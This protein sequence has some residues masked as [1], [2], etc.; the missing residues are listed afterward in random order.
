MT[1]NYK[2]VKRKL[3][4]ISKKEEQND[5]LITRKG[6]TFHVYGEY[7]IIKD[8]HKFKIYISEGDEL[9]NTVFNSS[10]AIAW[11]NAHKGNASPLTKN[12]IDTD[13][14]I[15]F[16]SNDI[17]YTKIL[18]SLKSTPHD[19]QSILLARLTEYVDKQLRLKLNLH[20]YIQRSKQI[21]SKGFLN[22][23]TTTSTTKEFNKVR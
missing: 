23:F 4:K 20:K 8:K 22:E 9:I 17:A 5:N 3:R 12:I 11:C 6:D 21:K 10:S 18:I 1:K 19:E 2:Q 16:L 14:A 15:E 13:R 7:R